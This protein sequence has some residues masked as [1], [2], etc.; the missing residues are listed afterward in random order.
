HDAAARQREAQV[1]DEQRVAVALAQRL[2]LDDDVAES[3]AGRD[4]DFGA[5]DLPGRLLGEQLLVGVQARLALRLPGARRHADPLEL[6]LQRALATALG[7]LLLREPLLL[8]LEP[9]RV[10]AFPR[11]GAAAVELEDPAGDVVEE[12]A[13]VGDGHDAAL[14]LLEEALE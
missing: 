3:R 12:V 7:L 13:V 5:L 9:R 1:V 11:I 6:A 2:G 10:I 8:L 14:V 4:V